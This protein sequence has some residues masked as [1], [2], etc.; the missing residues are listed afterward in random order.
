MNQ[1]GTGV[2][3]FGDGHGGAAVHGGGGR[4]YDGAAPVAIHQL[5]QR[6]GGAE[7]VLVVQ[8]GLLHA[9]AHRLNQVLHEARRV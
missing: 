9:L 1:V 7:V 4:K 6:H 2:T 8:Q 5:E 3:T